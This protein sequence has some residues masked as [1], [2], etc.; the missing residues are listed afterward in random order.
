MSH[1][2]VSVNVV[3]PSGEVG[4][5]MGAVI[6]TP[7]IKDEAWRVLRMKTNELG[8]HLVGTEA[9]HATYVQLRDL[10]I[11]EFEKLF[12]ELKT[13]AQEFA[14]RIE[15]ARKAKPVEDEKRE[16]LD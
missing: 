13:S 11:R 1:F 7:E 15:E 16:A 14:D 5:L 8:V 3:P 10:R 12:H 6:G 4:A 9:L 2:V